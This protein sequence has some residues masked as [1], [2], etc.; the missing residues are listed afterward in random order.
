[1]TG[2]LLHP[3]T[4]QELR[5]AIEH[6]GIIMRRAGEDILTFRI[7]HDASKIILKEAVGEIIAEDVYG[8]YLSLECKITSGC[9]ESLC[10]ALGLKVNEVIDLR[11]TNSSL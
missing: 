5:V 7:K 11:K 4:E 1:M 10:E 9:G 6:V 2:T 8:G 3:Q